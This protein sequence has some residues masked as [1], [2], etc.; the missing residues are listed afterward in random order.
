MVSGKGEENGKDRGKEW[1]IEKQGEKGEKRRKARRVRQ[2][3][4]GIKG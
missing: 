2:E 1:A 4:R 3:E